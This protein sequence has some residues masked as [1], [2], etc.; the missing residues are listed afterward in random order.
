[1]LAEPKLVDALINRSAG[2]TCATPRITQVFAVA[3]VAW[4]LAPPAVAQDHNRARAT[5]HA[6]RRPAVSKPAW[7]TLAREGC[8][9]SEVKP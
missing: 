9:Q 2:Q 7:P 1:M 3:T 8:P 4:R 5:V 6:F